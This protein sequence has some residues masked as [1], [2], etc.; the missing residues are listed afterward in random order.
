[1]VRINC[2]KLHLV[3]LISTLGIALTATRSYAEATLEVTP[4]SIAA[5]TIEQPATMSARLRLRAPA[6]ATLRS[7]RLT[8]FS[9]DGITVKIEDGDAAANIDALAPNDEHLWA[10]LLT[11]ARPLAKRA[12]V[13][14]E[15]AMSEDPTTEGEETVRRH[16]Y[17]SLVIEPLS[18]DTLT[19]L[20]GMEIKGGDQMV[21][22][23]RPGTV[24]LLLKNQRDL[25]VQVTNLQW[26]GPGFIELRAASADCAADTAAAAQSVSRRLGPYEQV[27]LPTLVCPGEQVVPGKYTLLAT[28]SVTADGAQLAV[29]SASQDIQV[30]VLGESELLNLLGVPSLLL[31]PGFLLIITWRILGSLRGASAEGGFELK[32]KEADFWAVAIAMSLAFAFLYPWVTEQ[33]LPE[34]RRDYLVAYG[35]RDLVYV[36][37][38]AIGLGIFTY[39][40]WRL[41]A[42]LK[43]SYNSWQ[44]A[45]CV[46]LE[47]D[48][49][50][51]VLE[52]LVRAKSEIELPLVH[53]KGTGSDQELFELTPWA[54][55]ETVW[56]APPIQLVLNDLS[57]DRDKQRAADNA[58]QDVTTGRGV[59]AATVCEIV[60]EGE[61]KGWWTAKWGQVGAVTGPAS[62]APDAIEG[63]H[64]RGRLV[65]ESP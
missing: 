50:I 24:Y 35:M 11:P 12:H 42:M 1:M 19:S 34:G 56:L 13:I 29:L 64:K 61:T 43:S 62:K 41:I 17:A 4:D 54:I 44:L 3:V 38:A 46:P 33:I 36:Y 7:V 47:S 48:S 26:F 22:R 57:A 58:L 63:L 39:G 23:Q 27:V 31:L 20:V 45:R 14:F 10:L 15:V 55:G 51:A 37:S 53:L 9:N 28:A 32:P 49:T 40:C 16:L 21:S 30:G 5:A 65:I 60:K 2:C 25:A 59:D 6:E 52:K 8:S 18:T